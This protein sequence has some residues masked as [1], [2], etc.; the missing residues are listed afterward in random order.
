MVSVTVI[1]F[2]FRNSNC[3]CE[4]LYFA[5]HLRNSDCHSKQL[6]DQNENNHKKEKI[7]C[8]LNSGQPGSEINYLRENADQNKAGGKTDPENRILYSKF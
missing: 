1:F 6:N 4:R 8:R 2:F 5:V 3:L 7:L